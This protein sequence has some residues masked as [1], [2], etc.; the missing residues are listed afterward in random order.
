M[1][2]ALLLDE[3]SNLTLAQLDEVSGGLRAQE[4]DD[5]Y[6]RIA[7][8][9]EREQLD[10]LLLRR[11]ENLSWLTAGQV[12]A[13]VLIPGETAVASL[14]VLR[15]G[16]RFY[17]AP[18][19]E[20]PRLAAEEFTGLG[21]EPVL[22]PWYADATAAQIEKLAGK[23]RIGSDSPGWLPVDLGALR[24]PLTEAEIL[25]YRWLGAATA[26]VVEGVLQALEPGDSEYDMEGVVARL[27]RSQ[28]IMPS[29]LLMAVDRR[30]LS[31]KHAVAR[32]AELERFGMINLCTRKW[33]L[34][35]SITR[36]VHF[37]PLPAE[38]ERGFAVAAEVN[39]QLL[40]V[41][42]NGVRAAE[43]YQV[44]ERSYAEAGFAGEELKHHQGGATGYAEREW[45]ATPEGE[46]VV[47]TPQAYAWNPSC[48][49]GKVEDTVLVTDSGVELLTATAELPVVETTVGGVAYRSAGV[50]QPG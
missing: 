34:A 3:E 35:V 30:I 16:R 27:L 39:A 7:D 25:R 42:R 18:E 41:T 8:F 13:R 48:R 20:A 38:I 12:E 50:L 40:H 45:V 43:L 47:T 2:E 26:S 5:K 23:V 6:G 32:G 24:A 44:A 14:L 11:H 31:Y 49:G 10:G 29:V 21:Y 37:G 28:G 46:Q 36:F 15:D 17:L 22:A 9:L 4:L 1:M 19:N 33:G